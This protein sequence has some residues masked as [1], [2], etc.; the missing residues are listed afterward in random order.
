MALGYGAR[1]CRQESCEIWRSGGREKLMSGAGRSANGP[2]LHH[3]SCASVADTDQGPKTE[4]LL[5]IP[6]DTKATRDRHSRVIGPFS[7]ILNWQRH[8]K[9]TAIPMKTNFSLKLKSA[10]R[11]LALALLAIVPLSARAGGG[12]SH[13]HDRI[14][15]VKHIIVIYQ[16]NWSFDSLYGQFPGANGLANG[17]DTTPQYAV[18]ASPPYSQLI[19]KTPRPLNGAVDPNFPASPDGFLA[20]FGDHNVALPLIPYDFT[21]YVAADAKTGDI[22]H[23]FYHEQLQ[24]DNGLL[25]PKLGDLGKF[26]TWSDNPGLVLSYLDATNLPE[27]L[28]AQE[29]GRASCRERV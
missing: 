27:G 10:A 23:R 11:R 13:A 1:A 28:L 24:I 21:N 20:W 16:E 25:E 8:H 19:Y 5:R 29:I 12:E 22:I 3:P 17:F 2:S 7:L 18:T 9:Q 14:E 6:H 15:K 4:R 26:V